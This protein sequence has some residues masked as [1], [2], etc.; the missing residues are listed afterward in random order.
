MRMFNESIRSKGRSKVFCGRTVSAAMS[1]IIPVM[2]TLWLLPRE[3][4][5]AAA[6]GSS[7]RN[8]R[9]LNA[10]PEKEQEIRAKLSLLP[11]GV[12]SAFAA[13]GWFIEVSDER[14]MCSRMGVS[15]DAGRDL[16]GLTSSRK[17]ILLDGE[18]DDAA[19]ACLHEMGHFADIY[20]EEMTGIRPSRT[21]EFAAL[22]QAEAPFLA[23]DEG[24]G[25]FSA[26][27]YYA[28]LFKCWIENPQALEAVPASRDYIAAQAA[29]FADLNP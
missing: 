26:G 23:A 7:F 20:A 11:D 2:L 18:K 21:A 10:S 12:C 3:A 14:S 22:Y 27:E 5:A 6:E 25:A 19:Y 8:I 9:V 1:L 28:E 15:Y 29:E 4:W 17:Y 13:D 24:Y 16:T